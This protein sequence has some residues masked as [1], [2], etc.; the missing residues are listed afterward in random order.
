ME[1]KKNIEQIFV[2]KEFKQTVSYNQHFRFTKLSGEIFM[3]T[4][5]IYLV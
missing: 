3:P 4:K 2:E 1:H 5:Q